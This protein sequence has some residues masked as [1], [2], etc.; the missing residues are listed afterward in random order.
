VFGS[1]NHPITES[2]RDVD[3]DG[4]QEISAWYTMLD[5]PL[6]ENLNVIGGARFES[7]KIGIVND[8][9]AEATWFPPGAEAETELIPG[10]ADVAFEQDDVLPSVGLVYEPI[11]SLTLRASYSETVARQTFK[12]LTPILQQEFLGGPTFIGNPELQM[13]SLE[14]YDLR[15]DWVPYDGGL[16]SVSWFHKDITD[17]IEYV[18][19]VETFTFTTARNY[20]EGRLGGYE[21]EVR[22]ALGHFVDSLDGLSVGANATFIDSQVTLPDDEVAAFAAPSLQVPIETRDATGA[23]EHLYNLYMTYDL[24]PTDT[25]VALFYTVQ[26]DTLVAGAAESQGNFVPSVYAKEY[27][28]LNLSLSQGIGEHFKLQFQVKNLTN[29]KIEEVYRS[30]FIGGDVTK[31]SYTAGIDYSI[32]LSA[33]FSF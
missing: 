23:P 18:Q 17:P 31:T 12:E 16:L 14:N 32:A 30:E 20:P 22:Q 3:Y 28:T 4:E 10:D 26:G 19:R 27:D 33:R 5:L 8:P 13:S 9:E 1:E 21:L 2:L 24:A 15:L 25:Q 6:A 7:T 29:P 11:E